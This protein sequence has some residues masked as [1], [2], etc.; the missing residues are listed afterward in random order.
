MY[1]YAVIGAVNAAIA[2]YYYAR[3]M[4]T[5]VIDAGNE[6]KPALAIPALEHAWILLL[7]AGNIAPLFVWWA[8]DGWTRGGLSVYAGR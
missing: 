4:K 1:A 7:A 2:A 8:I 6:D 5:M 3:V